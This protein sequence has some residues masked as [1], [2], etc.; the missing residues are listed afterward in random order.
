MCLCLL[1]ILRPPRST[2]TDTLLPYTT[3]FRSGDHPAHRG[4][5]GV[6]DERQGRRDGRPDVRHGDEH[7]MMTGRSTTAALAAA[8]VACLA[9]GAA[10]ARTL[11]PESGVKDLVAEEILSG[12]GERLE[13][14]GELAIRL[15]RLPVG[16][17]TG[18][19]W[20][21]GRGGQD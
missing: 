17:E 15:A 21:R 9:A 4:P 16:E 20:G 11:M 18:R 7:P 8:L 6:R 14:N 2:R 19:A 5:A 3:L 1:M 13:E 12:W 10:E